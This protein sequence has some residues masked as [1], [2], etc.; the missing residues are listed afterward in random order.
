MGSQVLKV[1]GLYGAILLVS[2]LL[3]ACKSRV[4]VPYYNTADFTPV[5]TNDRAVIDTL[6]TVAPFSV[7]DQEGKRITN[8]TFAGKV[9]VADFFFTSCPGIC[10]KLTKHMK[11]LADSFAGN[12]EVNFISYSVTP[13]IDS[14]PRLKA[15]GREHAIDASQWHR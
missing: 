3:F 10:P 7:T 1:A 11:M 12:S 4:K 6:H 5:W 15:Y 2:T 14:V 8:Q 13:D 9:Y